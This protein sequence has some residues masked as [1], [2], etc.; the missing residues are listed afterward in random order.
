M[1]SCSSVWRYW[2]GHGL[3]PFSPNHTCSLFILNLFQ[4]ESSLI[5]HI[6]F[7]LYIN[8][9]VVISTYNS[10][11]LCFYLHTTWWQFKACRSPVLT[12]PVLT[13]PLAGRWKR[14]RSAWT[15]Y[16]W[17]SFSGTARHRWNIRCLWAPTFSNPSR[18]SSSIT[19]CSRYLTCWP[20]SPADLPHLLTF[21]TSVVFHGMNMMINLVL[22]F[23]VLC[24]WG[25]HLCLEKSG[26]NLR[27]FK[28]WKM[29]EDRHVFVSLH[30]SLQFFQ[31][32][33][34]F[35]VE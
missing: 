8:L 28:A 16:L 27:V 34:L 25:F 6:C 13:S 22:I 2:T 4:V 14:W 26:I 7:H 24:F 32:P 1:V 21:L 3:N 35:S 15:I 20:S 5:V 11:F 18:G 12:S 31:V 10:P 23:L 9:L 29:M 33:Y 19:C 30:P 17:P